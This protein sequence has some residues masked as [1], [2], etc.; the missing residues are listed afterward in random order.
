M[1]SGQTAN[2]QLN[3]WEAEDKVLRTEFNADNVKIDAAL[4][5]YVTGSYTGTG[6]LTP[7]HYSLGGRPKLLVLATNNNYSGNTHRVFLIA[8]ENMTLSYSSNGRFGVSFGGLITLD[9]D[10]FTVDHSLD[11]EHLGYNRE[12]YQQTYWAIC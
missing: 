9:D 6:T 11:E 12:G 3:Q 7:T 4:P 10:G 5:R 2:Y 8:L 1:A